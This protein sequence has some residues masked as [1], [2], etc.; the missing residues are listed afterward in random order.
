MEGTAHDFRQY[1]LLPCSSAVLGHSVEF[2]FAFQLQVAKE[3]MD[4]ITA[5][6]PMPEDLLT[7]TMAELPET[8]KPSKF[9]IETSIGDTRL[10]SEVLRNLSKDLSK[11][12]TAQITEPTLSNIENYQEKAE[13]QEEANPHQTSDGIVA[14]SC[15][16]AFSES[17]FHSRVLTEF[18][19]RVQ[20]FP[21]LIPHTLRQLQLHFKQSACYPSACPY[22][23]FQHLRKVQLQEC[24]GVPIRPWNP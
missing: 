19:E 6:K 4:Q 8:E 24:P 9:V 3:V 1:L 14:F 18:V 12:H 21:I 7:S 5:G 2:S 13:L 16:H 11:T 15:G 20:D 17:Q 22:C 23:V 10:W